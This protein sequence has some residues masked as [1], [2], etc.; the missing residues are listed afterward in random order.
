MF[1]Y[2]LSLQHLLGILNAQEQ[3]LPTGLRILVHAT[4]K[5]TVEPIQFVVQMVITF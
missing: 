5:L 4:S 3:K 1:P 2:T